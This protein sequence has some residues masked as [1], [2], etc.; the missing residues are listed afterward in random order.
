M[1]CSDGRRHHLGVD[2]VLWPRA[3]PP[4]DAGPGAWL[5]RNRGQVEIPAKRLG[6]H[7]S[8]NRRRQLALD[9]ALLQLGRVVAAGHGVRARQLR[10]VLSCRRDAG[11]SVGDSKAGNQPGARDSSAARIHVSVGRGSRPL[12]R[13]SA[14]TGRGSGTRPRKFDTRVPGQ[15]TCGDQGTQTAGGG[16]RRASSDNKM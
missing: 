3:A 5:E 16:G 7:G 15:G 13:P 11:T 9:A 1:A 8:R 10:H 12:H 2:A 4:T 6:R 14:E